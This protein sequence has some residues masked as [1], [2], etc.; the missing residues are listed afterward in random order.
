MNQV[1]MVGRIVKNPE[2]EETE[3]GKKVTNM[4]I[5]VTRSYKNADG[6][7]E[8]D[9]VDCTLWDTVAERTCEYCKQGDIVG[10]K[11]RIQSDQYEV[12]GEKKKSLRVVADRVTFL[13]SKSKD[14][15]KEESEEDLDM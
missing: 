2:V 13:S 5:A 11:G 14:T 4:T 10:I 6:V 7:Y 15:E 12:D 3:N 9:F 8:T 1:V